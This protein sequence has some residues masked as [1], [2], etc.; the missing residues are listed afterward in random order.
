MALSPK[1]TEMTVL[2]TTLYENSVTTCDQSVLR[3]LERG[4]E[5]FQE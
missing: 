1:N 3:L 2:A 5:S 4:R